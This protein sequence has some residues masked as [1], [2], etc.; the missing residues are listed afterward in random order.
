MRREKS[1]ESAELEYERF[2][3]S[4]HTELSENLDSTFESAK[5]RSD[6]LIAFLFVHHRE[7]ECCKGGTPCD[8]QQRR[9]VVR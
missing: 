6:D 9:D 8:L 3:F 5:N 1:C 4:D 2:S 7:T